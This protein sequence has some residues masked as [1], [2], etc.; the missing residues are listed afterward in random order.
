MGVLYTDGCTTRYT[1]QLMALQVLIL[2][3]RAV[4]SAFERA[5]R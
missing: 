2:R 1:N 4:M 3:E 5:F